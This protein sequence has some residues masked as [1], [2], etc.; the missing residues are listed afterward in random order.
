MLPKLENLDG[1][2]VLGQ[3]EGRSTELNVLLIVA[4]GDG[5]IEAAKT[6]ALKRYPEADDILNVEVDTNHFNV[7]SVFNKSTTILR[8]LAVKYK[9]K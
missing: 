3:V 6:D 5:G 7:L 8:G 2:E 9:K 4:I 1:V